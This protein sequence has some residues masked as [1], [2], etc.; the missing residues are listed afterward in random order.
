MP[1]DKT[2]KTGSEGAEPTQEDGQLANSANDTPDADAQKKESKPTAPEKSPHITR[3]ILIDLMGDSP[4]TD[5]YER[6]D[7]DF[8]EGSLCAYLKKEIADKG[9]TKAMLIELTGINRRFFFDI[10]SCKRHPRRRYVIR[11]FLALQTPFGRAQRILRACGYAVLFA[12]DRRDAVIIRSIARNH[13]V[14]ECNEILHKHGLEP[15]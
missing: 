2:K 14:D 7:S 9:V 8:V 10:L 3:D 13:S 11:F 6:N 12:R 5:V 15:I 4:M 1:D